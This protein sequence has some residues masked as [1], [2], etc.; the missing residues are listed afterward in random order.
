ML[1]TLYLALGENDEAYQMLEN[2][3]WA[4]SP[5]IVL[6]DVDPRFDSLRADLRFQKPKTKNCP[7]KFTGHSAGYFRRSCL[8]GCKLGVLENLVEMFV[9][10]I[11]LKTIKGS[12]L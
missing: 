10:S 2:G 7:A 8:G 12:Q 11:F 1:S 5:R 9:P 6:S 4:H 3:C